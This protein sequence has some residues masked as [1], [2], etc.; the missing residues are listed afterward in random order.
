MC[1]GVGTSAHKIRSLMR[2]LRGSSPRTLTLH[3]GEMVYSFPVYTSDSCLFFLMLLLTCSPFSMIYPEPC[4]IYLYSVDLQA[5]LITPKVPHQ[6]FF[7]RPSLTL[8]SATSTAR[9]SKIRFTLCC[10]D[11]TPA[12]WILNSPTKMHVLKVQ[13][14]RVTVCKREAE[15]TTT[16]AVAK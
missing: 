10:V 12:R 9:L 8:P 16:S 5:R 3:F 4:R 1:T 15:N 14:D 6:F 11:R 13:Q 2:R 7:S